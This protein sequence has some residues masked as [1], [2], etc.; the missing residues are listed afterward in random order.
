MCV[1]LRLE[2]F[3]RLLQTSYKVY[4]VPALNISC[5]SRMRIL[6]RSLPITEEGYL[7]MRRC[8]YELRTKQTHVLGDITLSRLNS[9]HLC[10]QFTTNKRGGGGWPAGV[11][12]DFPF[13]IRSCIDHRSFKCEDNRN[14]PMCR[15]LR[16]R[17]TFLSTNAHWVGLIYSQRN[18]VTVFDSIIKMLKLLFYLY[19]WVG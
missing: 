2:M 6:S 13:R 19:L 9:A 3:T 7:N 14:F 11:P 17:K 5:K 4:S 10:L 18:E 12:D 1:G 15:G 16:N 8:G